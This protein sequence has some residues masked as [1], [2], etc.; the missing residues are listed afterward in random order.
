[1]QT[2]TAIVRFDYFDESDGRFRKT[3]VEHI[4]FN[5]IDGLMDVIEEHREKASRKVRTME[6][7]IIEVVE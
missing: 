4:K 6:Y 1:M 2:M 5:S 7:T 3:D